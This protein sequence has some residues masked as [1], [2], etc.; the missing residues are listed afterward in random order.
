MPQMGSRRSHRS[1]MP[2][3]YSITPM[4]VPHQH[5]LFS[6][7]SD[8]SFTL[9]Y[10]WLNL[11]KPTMTFLPRF[12]LSQRTSVVLLTKDMMVQMQAA[13]ICIALNVLWKSFLHYNPLICNHQ[14]FFQGFEICGLFSP[15]DRRDACLRL[16]CKTI[17]KSW[18]LL[19]ILMYSPTSDPLAD[20]AQNAA[21]RFSI[22]FV[23][24]NSSASAKRVAT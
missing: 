12:R 17:V 21:N 22:S 14:S 1:C 19:N 8:R 3:R 23:L 16:A 20:R 9:V 15:R 11:G 6:Q 5:Y 13:F 4:I 24:P 18:R 10:S 2:S 7:A